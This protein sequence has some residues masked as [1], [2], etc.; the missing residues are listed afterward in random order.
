MRFFA[1]AF[2]DHFDTGLLDEIFVSLLQYGNEK[3]SILFL[4]QSLFNVLRCNEHLQ[5]FKIHG[6]RF[7]TLL[8]V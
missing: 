3:R 2:D 1:E 5:N 6:I 8:K 4:S 7:K